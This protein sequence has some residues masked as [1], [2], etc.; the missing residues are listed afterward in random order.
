MKHN[1][2]RREWMGYY[3][4]WWCRD[5]LPRRSNEG[6]LRRRIPGVVE[7][8]PAR[9]AMVDLPPGLVKGTD[10]TRGADGGTAGDSTAAAMEWFG[11]SD[12][13]SKFP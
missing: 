1:E 12:L 10:S 5:P 7:D 3:P 6:D 13:L 4:R 11:G 2:K 8:S 9:D